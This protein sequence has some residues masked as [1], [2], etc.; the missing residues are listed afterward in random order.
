MK[1]VTLGSATTTLTTINYRKE[2]AYRHPIIALSVSLGD[3]DMSSHE[4]GQPFALYTI[5]RI[6]Q[7]SDKLEDARIKIFFT[8]FFNEPDKADKKK[9]IEYSVNVGLHDVAL[10]MT[11]NALGVDS[12]GGLAMAIVNRDVVKVNPKFVLTGEQIAG[13]I[14]LPDKASKSSHLLSTDLVNIYDGIYAQPVSS[15]PWYKDEEYG[16][17]ETN[18]LF[19]SMQ[20]RLLGMVAGLLRDDPAYLLSAINRENTFDDILTLVEGDDTASDTPL[21]GESEEERERSGHLFKEKTIQE[22]LHR[23]LFD[24]V[25]Y[26][27]SQARFADPALRTVVGS[28]DAVPL[29]EY[30]LEVDLAFSSITSDPSLENVFSTIGSVVPTAEEERRKAQKELWIE[31][32]ELTLARTLPRVWSELEKLPATLSKYQIIA[33]ELEKAQELEVEEEVKI[34]ASLGDDYGYGAVFTTRLLLLVSYVV[35]RQEIITSSLEDTTFSPLIIVN[36][37]IGV[38]EIN[39]EDIWEF[40]TVIDAVL[41]YDLETAIDIFSMYA[42]EED[43]V[44]TAYYLGNVLHEIS[45]YLL[46]G[47]PWDEIAS[48]SLIDIAR[49]LDIGIPEFAPFLKWFE[50][51]LN[52]LEEEYE[53]EDGE[54]SSG[55]CF[56]ARV[57]ERMQEEKSLSVKQLASHT[58]L[59]LAVLADTHAVLEELE[60]SSSEWQNSR[61]IFLEETMAQISKK[62]H[63]RIR[64]AIR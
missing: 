63:S 24:H 34:V 41:S 53:D 29:E 56:V 9:D 6:E 10:M 38:D 18:P 48:E 61:R 12:R 22:S 1:K 59:L 51:L 8:Q 19:Q 16:K 54:E 37:W 55:S 35:K 39:H 36:E 40:S 50:T 43:N 26:A 49:D 62:M 28:Y 20:S 23:L 42:T 58:S 46:E 5:Q 13:L 2:A 32:F 4:E 31:P 3:R 64:L 57:I 30:E 27:L 7:T 17:T 25:A 60:T 11:L 33:E 52:L 44:N 45:H 14:V 47:E 15:T 21:Q